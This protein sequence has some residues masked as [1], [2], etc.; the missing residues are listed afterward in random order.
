[1]EGFTQLAWISAKAFFIAIVATPIIRDVFRSYNVV[2]RPGR[3]KIHR[4]PIP[5][6][7]GAAIALAYAVSL[8]SLRD[9]GGSLPEHSSPIWA[10]VWGAGAV[11]LIGLLD[12]LFDLKPVFKIAGELAAAVLVFWNGVRVETIGGAPVPLWLSFVLTLAWLLL[13]TNALNLIDGLDGLCAGMG[14]CA[15]LTLFG[16]ALIYGNFPLAHATLP[17]AG[18]L[19]G[20]LFYNFSP[21]TVFLGDSGALLIGFL[22]GCFGM[23]WTQKTTTLLSVTVPLLALSIPLLDVSISVLRRFLRN[24]PIF[25]ADRGH[26][27]HKLLE[28]GLS[29]QRAV[30]ILYTASIIPAGLAL[31]LSVPSLRRYQAYVVLAFCIAAWAGIRRLRYAEFDMVG[32]LLFG[33]E[34]QRTVAARVRL[35]GLAAAL[36]GSRDEE[37]WWDTVVQAARELKWARVCWLG[38]RSI[39]EEQLSSGGAATWSFRI[40][41]SAKETVLAEGYLDPATPQMDLVRFADVLA[42]THSGNRQKWGSPV[43]P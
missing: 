17:L 23:L 27:H 34:F 41:L 40:P 21:A 19:L 39:R 4:H 43:L 18:A 22:L 30:L 20:F 25:G 1:M 14:L 24:R 9:I 10:L 31:A 36:E 33:G 32:D 16:A 26:I 15:T 13:T 37:Q 6:V 12:D 28:L 29:P 42:R 38:E 2:D 11:F 35:K 5:R 8:V 3:R 7:G